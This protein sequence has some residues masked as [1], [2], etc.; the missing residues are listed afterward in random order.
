MNTGLLFVVSA[1]SGTGKTSLVERLVRLVPD[2]TK[3]RSYTSRAARRGERDGVDYNFVSR[4]AFDEMVRREAFLEWAEVFGS[5]YGTAR[6]D[7]STVLERGVDVVLVIDV[8]GARQIRASDIPATSIFVMPPSPAVLE[9][10][11]RGRSQ[12]SDAQIR[13]RLEVARREVQ[14]FREYDYLVVND[15]FDEAVGRLQGIVLGCRASMSRARA[16]AE[17]I[18]EQFGALPSELA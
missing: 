13:R 11:L 17:A 3:S 18:A 15:D 12:D 16:Q 1:P 9:S 4:A 5:L 8:Q 10:R 7:T 6:A 14:A 2:L